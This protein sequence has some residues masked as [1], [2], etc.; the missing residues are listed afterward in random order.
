MAMAHCI[1]L[2][3]PPHFT[4]GG[5][6]AEQNASAMDGRVCHQRSAAAIHP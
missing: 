2:T 3:A 5:G 6:A 1:Q 4:V